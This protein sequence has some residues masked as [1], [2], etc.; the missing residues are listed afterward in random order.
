M[1]S[2][3]EKILL[4]MGGLAFSFIR[5]TIITTQCRKIIIYKEYDIILLFWAISSTI[6]KFRNTFREK[7]KITFRFKCQK[8]FYVLNE[9]LNAISGIKQKKILALVISRRFD[10]SQKLDGSL[11]IH[12]GYVHDIKINRYGIIRWR[13]E[14][15]LRIFRT[16]IYYNATVAKMAHIGIHIAKYTIYGL[17]I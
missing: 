17:L 8:T 6:T 5:S 12:I 11:N 16:S 14:E 13:D 4:E 7:W 2:I 9:R 1:T 15:M 3:I 10:I